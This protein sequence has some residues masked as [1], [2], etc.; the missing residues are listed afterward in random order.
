MRLDHLPAADQVVLLWNKAE[1]VDFAVQTLE[2]YRRFDFSRCQRFVV[3]IGIQPEMR[4]GIGFVN[5]YFKGEVAVAKHATAMRPSLIVACG[6]SS[7][8]WLCSLRRFVATARSQGNW[9]Q[10]QEYVSVHGR[11][12]K[13]E[14]VRRSASTRR[15][16]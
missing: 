6:R 4:R 10:D 14:A 1:V 9:K 2:L 3:A 11:M 13:A 12:S 8:L 5:S 15:R 16:R 7:V